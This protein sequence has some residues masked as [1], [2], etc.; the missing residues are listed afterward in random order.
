MIPWFERAILYDVRA[1]P[2]VIAST[3]GSRDL[4]MV[5]IS[6]RVLTK[7]NQNHLQNIY[8]TLG[9]DYDQ[10]VLPSI[11]QE[12]LK[13]VIAQYNASQLLTQREMVSKDIRRVLQERAAVFNIILEDVSITNL[14]FSREFTAAIE[15]KQVRY[16]A[17]P[18]LSLPVCARTRRQSTRRYLR[19]TCCRPR[20]GP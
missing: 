7:P 10:R 11:I 9:M 4:Q 8:R 12:T 3:S 5:N 13:S 20:P 2:N 18:A 14:T 16:R 19:R 15:A 6:L 1:R 17:R